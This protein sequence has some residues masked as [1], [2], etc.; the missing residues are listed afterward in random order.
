[1]VEPPLL[2]RLVQSVASTPCSP[3]TGVTMLVAAV[4]LAA[5]AAQAHDEK[6]QAP[7]AARL[8]PDLGRRRDVHPERRR[9]VAAGPR[10]ARVSACRACSCPPDR[11]L[12]LQPG[13]SAFHRAHQARTTAPHRASSWP[14]SPDLGARPQT[15]EKM[16]LRASGTT[17]Y[18]TSQARL[19][20]AEGRPEPHRRQPDLVHQGVLG[21]RARRHRAVQ[22]RRAD[23]K[24]DESNR[25]FQV[26]SRFAEI[27][28][29]PDKVPNHVMG[30]IFE[31]L[32]RRFSEARTRRRASTSPRA[33][34][35]A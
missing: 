26:V 19:R 2:A 23:R 32:I 9:F 7:W 4:D 10:L 20:E 33:R 24:L 28:L 12:G 34:S 15:I 13:L 30:Y 21:E 3:A 25:L 29:H 18:N 1:M 27:D 5:V 17:F 31:E 11:E 16:L 6:L 35:S 8:P 22:V 14:I